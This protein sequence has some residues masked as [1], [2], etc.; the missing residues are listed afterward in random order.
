LKEKYEGSDRTIGKYVDRIS[1]IVSNIRQ[2]GDDF[3]NKRI[4][5]KVLVTLLERFESKIYS[6]EESK[7]LKTLSPWES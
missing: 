7:D 1:S 3:S 2:L 6:L 4:V 5:E